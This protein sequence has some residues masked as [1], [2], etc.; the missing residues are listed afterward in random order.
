MERRGPRAE[1]VQTPDKRL[2]RGDLGRVELGVDNDEG[3]LGGGGGAWPR[4]SRDGRR[5]VRS[6]GAGRWALAKDGRRR[7]LAAQRK[8]TLKWGLR[9]AEARLLGQT[10]TKIR[11]SLAERFT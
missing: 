7:G 4:A 9:E 10:K 5:M 6:S 8:R 1:E 3:K 2:G 11:A